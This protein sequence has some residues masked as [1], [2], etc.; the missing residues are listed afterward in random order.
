MHI[1]PFSPRRGTPAATMPDQVPPQ[2]KAERIER[3]AELEAAQRQLY[4]RS[5]VGRRLT[6]AVEGALDMTGNVLAGLACR[7]APVELHAESGVAIGSL[8]TVR[9][10]QVRDDRLIGRVVSSA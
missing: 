1:F 4:Y 3:L 8:V 7:Y 2:L 5:L 6:V 9:A 10:D